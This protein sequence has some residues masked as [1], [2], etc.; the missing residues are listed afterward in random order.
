MSTL[1]SQDRPQE[2]HQ[3][4]AFFASDLFHKVQ[5]SGIFPDS[6]HFADATPKV[7]WEEVYHQFEL[8]S[9]LPDFS[10]IE[11]VNDNFILP[12]PIQLEHQT[13]HKTVCAH[14]EALWSVLMKQP[15]Q[16]SKNSLLPLN[17]PYL[18]PGGRFREIY[19]WDSYFT[20]LGLMVSGRKSLVKSMVKNF[21]QLQQSIGCI[22][23][24]NRSYYYS[25]SQPPVLGM[26]VDM[27][28][29]TE[30]ENE[31][32][33]FLRQCVEAME[34]EYAY[35][36]QGSEK[37]S[38]SFQ[39]N[40]H[41]LK[42][43]NGGYLNRY[44]DEQASPRPE[45]YRE[46]MH[47]AANKHGDEKLLFYRNIRAA[48][49]S[50]WDFSSRWLADPHDLESIQTTN[51]VPVDLNCLMYKL[52]VLLSRYWLKLGE[53]QKSSEFLQKS[54]TRKATIQAYLWDTENSYFVDFNLKT[55][56]QSNVLSLAG[57]LPL[58]TELAS[59]SQADAVAHRLT[60]Q[61]LCDGGLITTLCQSE[62]QWD[63]PNGWA[64]L[65]WFA[66]KGLQ[67][68]QHHATAT[69]IMQKWI[70]TVEHYYDVHGSLMEKYNVKEIEHVAQGGEY[71][72][73]HGFG[74]T[75]GVTLA[76]YQLLEKAS[77]QA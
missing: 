54:D 60:N 47:A 15:D 13:K 33:Q 23:N 57:V 48:C 44:W 21:I 37:L 5:V 35:W 55:K 46:D 74:W 7:A 63:A 4:L 27:L 77:A 30:E 45:S 65:Q 20:A 51:I 58:F 70:A 66:V 3:S 75:N 49:E 50:G 38:D 67:H 24:G 32:P 12:K 76:F 42:M 9:S 69:H 26:M 53:S 6:K 41:V 39:T 14:I 36:M 72:V 2:F 59:Q 8:Q 40:R 22:P 29:A 56:M 1:K 64:P 61:F 11:F 19:Y 43:P 68:Y 73:Q 62:Q 17:F 10:L 28:F 25:R 16:Q 18:V 31:D 71:E 34:I 52:E